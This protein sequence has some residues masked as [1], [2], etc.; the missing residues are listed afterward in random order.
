MKSRSPED[1]VS[2]VSTLPAAGLDIG[3]GG[4]SPSCAGCAGTA[5]PG[6]NQRLTS[7]QAQAVLNRADHIPTCSRW[8]AAHALL[9]AGLDDD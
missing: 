3:A 4:E 7:L 1:G 9:S 5:A 2:V 6:G 8:V